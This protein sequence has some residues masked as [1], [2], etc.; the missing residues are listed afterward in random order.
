MQ[1]NIDFP[2]RNETL[3]PELVNI[4]STQAGLNTSGNSQ[5]VDPNNRTT[6]EVPPT[7]P[8]QTRNTTTTGGVTQP[9]TNNTAGGGRTPDG[10]GIPSPAQPNT[11]QPPPITSSGTTTQPV[12]PA[13][14]NGTSSIPPLSTSG[15]FSLTNGAVPLILESDLTFKSENIDAAIAS[16]VAFQRSLRFLRN[17]TADFYNASQLV[18][19]DSNLTTQNLSI[20]RFLYRVANGSLYRST[21]YYSAASQQQLLNSTVEVKAQTVKAMLI[22]SQLFDI[23]ASIRRLYRDYL[24]GSELKSIDQQELPELATV[25]YLMRYEGALGQY[26]VLARTNSG[27]LSVMSFAKV[28]S[29]VKLKSMFAILPSLTWSTIQESITTHRAIMD[30]TRRRFN[31]SQTDTISISATSNQAGDRLRF[32]NSYLIDGN[33]TT[34]CASLGLYNRL[35]TIDYF[36]VGV[37]ASQPSIDFY[38]E[39]DY[40]DMIND[41]TFLLLDSTARTAYASLLFGVPLG[42]IE[43]R[44]VPAG[45]AYRLTYL[46]ERNNIQVGYNPQ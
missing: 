3:T 21:V 1:G 24:N 26:D 13:A 2:A 11:T 39:S 15:L 43:Y 23:D 35:A 42:K 4:I 32:C 20:Y 30:F 27:I 16:S 44:V 17:A 31:P 10:P 37:V 34:I 7:T 29:L 38:T 5:L 40:A 18:F 33:F 45:R 12:S 28:S 41:T 19:V 46:G 8:N 25:I 22:G 9:L 6:S 36:R 14:N